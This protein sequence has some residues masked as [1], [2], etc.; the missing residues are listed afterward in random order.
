M[1]PS[2]QQ[3]THS[4]PLIYPTIDHALQS[5]PSSQQESQ[6]LNGYMISH[7]PR[8]PPDS[9]HASQVYHQQHR[10][11]DIPIPQY[12]DYSLP[13]QINVQSPQQGY[14]T[15]K[16]GR[17]GSPQNPSSPK[18]AR[19]R[20]MGPE[21]AERRIC[22]AS[23]G[24][25][26]G[27]GGSIGNSTH[28]QGNG[29]MDGSEMASPISSRGTEGRGSDESVPQVECVDSKDGVDVTPSKPANME[30]PPPWS[31]LKTKAGKERKRLPLACIACRRKKIRC[32]GEKPACKHC[33]RSRIPCV[34]KIT[35]RKAAPRTDYMAMLDKRL[36]RMEERVIKIIPEQEASKLA[37][38]GRANVK[39]SIT[40]PPKVA[41]AKK[42]VA[43]EA[44]GNEL[45]EWAHVAVNTPAGHSRPPTAIDKFES[46]LLVEGVES[47]P[48][49]EI[50]EH[51]SEV[52]FDCLY[53]QSYHVLHKPSFMRRLRLVFDTEENLLTYTNIET[54]RALYRQYS[55]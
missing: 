5:P 38:I 23:V 47:L 6:E 4:Y 25:P 32:S 43:D 40:P 54:E 19:T 30:E 12:P 26:R 14:K 46:R 8:P 17:V 53:G 13:Y 37:R 1:P 27:S 7:S 33:L 29:S 18:H 22:I 49:K 51:L 16:G 35:T 21:L 36:K 52:F 41:G 34:Y 42:R 50:Q 11:S 20:G 48:S 45:E 3:A 24:A 31:E 44:F 28:P 2:A 55:F 15:S 9:S 39:P 10:L